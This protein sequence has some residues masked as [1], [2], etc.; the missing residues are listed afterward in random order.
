MQP[1]SWYL[2]Y[3][4]WAMDKENELSQK[5]ILGIVNNDVSND[6]RVK[7]VAASAAAGGFTSL[8]LGFSP[9]GRNEKVL[10]GS[11]VIKRIDVPVEVSTGRK[12]KK[13]KAKKRKAKFKK[14]VVTQRWRRYIA[15][16]LKP[17]VLLPL[18]R[19]LLRI[20]QKNLPFRFKRKI[21]FILK[22]FFNRILKLVSKTRLLKKM[23]ESR[24]GIR[25]LRVVLSRITARDFEGYYQREILV[26][27]PDLIHA[28]D[29]QMIGVAVK[30]ARKLREIGHHAKVI[31]D[32]HELVEGLDHLQKP[33][34]EFWLDY[35]GQYIK[36]VDGVV[37]VSDLQAQRLQERYTLEK[38]PSVI[39]NCPILDMEKTINRTVRDDAQHEGKLLVYHG[40]AS[41]ARGL[42]V[43][44]ESLE[45]LDAETHIALIVDINNPFVNELSKIANEIKIRMG[46]TSDRL[47]LLP[48]VSAEDLPTYLS[49]AD[50]AVIPLLPTGNHEV[51]MPNK[52]FEAV[53]ARLP[54]LT[55]QRKALSE[56]VVDKQIGQVF[57][58]DDPKDLAEVASQILMNIEQYK[59]KFS[60][61]YLQE[62][63]W[64][65][66][67]ELLVNSYQEQLGLEKSSLRPVSLDEIEL[68]DPAEVLSQKKV[69]QE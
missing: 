2:K 37:C 41:K 1:T 50:I 55:S 20:D 3:D 25:N 27:K 15:F 34:Q 36:E 42:E 43:L 62:C 60:D 6:N 57:K 47:H 14:K 13:R 28:H 61:N 38:K 12:A 33:I 56:Y 67:S 35:E 11:V 48:Y 22:L 9:E 54:I 4:I 49:T 58:D 19:V 26:I 10:M 8:I 65:T 18:K 7:R 23:I 69:F 51:A 63:S 21:I 52:L 30:A 44:V 40:K 46:G 29:F 68:S 45:Y 16:L 66:Q 31:Y 53:Q 64:D 24:I 32:A 39:L 5:I 17:K 59:S